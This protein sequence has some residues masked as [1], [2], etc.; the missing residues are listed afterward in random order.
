MATPSTKN[1]S[2]IVDSASKDQ[3]DKDMID[4]IMENDKD[5]PGEENVIE[6]D[7][8]HEVIKKR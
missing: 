5:I 7:D 8:S 6:D 2:V 1:N 3:N 4:E